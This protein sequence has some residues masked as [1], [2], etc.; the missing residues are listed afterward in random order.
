MNSTKI[1]LATVLNPL[2]DLKCDYWEKGAL[3][4][5]NDKIL[6][7]GSAS[8]MIKKYEGKKKVE[9]IDC[10]D[11]ILLPSFFDMHF[12][13]VQDD[14][15]EMPKDNLLEWLKNYTWPYE[16]KFKNKSYAKKKAKEFFS[17]LVQAGTLGG[18][19]YSS[20]HEV[21]LEE[22]MD[23][24]IGDFV[25][26]NVLMTMNSPE[27]LSET[28]EEAIKKV[29]KFSKLYKSRY[30][31]TP[32]FAIT[33]DM[34]VMQKGAKLARQNK[35]FMQTHLSETKNE[36]DFVLSLFPEYKTYTGIYEGANMLSDRTIM[37][38]G[39]HLS[40]LELKLLSKTKTVIAH[41]PTS[42][43]PL[44][45]KGL[46]SGLFDFEKAEKFKVRWAL[47]S[48]IGG[49]PYLSMF[50]VMRSFVAQNSKKKKATY[51]KALYRSTLAGAE[52]LKLEK[53]SGNLKPGKIA[54]FI[55]TPKPMKM[56]KTAEETLQLLLKP[57]AKKRQL[58]DLLPNNVFFH[59]KQLL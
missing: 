9:F 48:D 17:R 58:Y 59:G 13:W 18:A 2:S 11:N 24:V 22:A 16:A 1:Y 33:T 27:Y 51:V 21:A 38:H 35:S 29:T 10:S 49:G 5:K 39:I 57:L 30:A 40:D 53:T 23:H 31:M 25:I 28:K 47:G 20:L 34:D 7:L 14:V 4:V 3:V 32:R 54:N 36:I 45:E 19:C 52:V 46:G 6:D 43:A 37:G 15:R 8:S 55:L 41:C 50:D 26:G 56:G 44:K 12:H 42:N